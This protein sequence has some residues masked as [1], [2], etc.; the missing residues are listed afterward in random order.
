M[1]IDH[2]IR[3]FQEKAQPEFVISKKSPCESYIHLSLFD[4]YLGRDKACVTFLKLF[5]NFPYS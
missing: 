4:I 2:K 5:T 3:P 1:V